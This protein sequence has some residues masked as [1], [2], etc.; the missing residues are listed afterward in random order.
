MRQQWT[1]VHC[2]PKCD[3]ERALRGASPGRCHKNASVCEHFCDNY[4]SRTFDYKIVV[5]GAGISPMDEQT[6]RQFIAER[7]ALNLS[8]LADELGID[9]VNLDKIITGIHKIQ[10]AKRRQFFKVAKKY[11]YSE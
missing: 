6:F 8:A 5:K 1:D 9:R 11:G 4:H 2:C 7:A 10:P 3:A